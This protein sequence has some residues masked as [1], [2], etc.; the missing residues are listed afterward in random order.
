MKENSLKPSAMLDRNWVLKRKRRKLP[1]GIVKSGDRE[2]GYKSLKFPSTTLSKLELK[3]NASLDGC[4]GKRKG[5]DGYYY[6]CVI[7]ELGG[8]LL[9]CDSCPRT[10]HLEC[11]DPVL[12]R[13]PSGKWEC[14]MCCQRHASLESVNHLDPISKRARTKIVI[15]R[16]KTETE[17]S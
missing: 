3:E 14:P 17:S 6:E 1:A 8:K 12:K 2:K 11:L 5:N 7:C 16:S 15:R 9:C 4:S 13:I 10:Y